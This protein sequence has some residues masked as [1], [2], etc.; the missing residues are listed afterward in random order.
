[1]T[2]IAAYYNLGASFEHLKKWELSLSAFKRAMTYCMKFIPDCSSEMTDKIRV[3]INQVQQKA[4]MSHTTSM[5]RQ[6]KREDL[7][8]NSLDPR[9]LETLREQRGIKAKKLAAEWSKKPAKALGLRENK[10]K[11][12]AANKK[13][14]TIDLL[15]DKHMKKIRHGDFRTSMGSFDGR[16]FDQQMQMGDQVMMYEMQELGLQPHT[17]RTHTSHRLARSFVG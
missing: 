2:L 17:D 11:G 4:A 14:E 15:Y 3:S 16:Q 10:N 1:M 9:R 6:I 5:I 12:M 7:A 8:P 13:L